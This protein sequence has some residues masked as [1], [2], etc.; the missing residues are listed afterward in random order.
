MSWVKTGVAAIALAA[1]GLAVAPHAALAGVVVSSSGPSAGDY[2]AGTKIGDDERITL[3]A[4]DTLTVLD[5]NGTRI[6]RGAGTYML[7]QRSAA[8]RS[9]A[10]AALTT[11]RSARRART[12][13]VR[14]TIEEVRNPNLWYVDVRKSGNVCLFDNGELN[15]WRPNTSEEAAYTVTQGGGSTTVVFPEGE[16]LGS[17]DAAMPIAEGAPYSIAGPDGQTSTVTFKAIDV[18]VEDPEALAAELIAQGCT[19]QL[20]QLTSASLIPAG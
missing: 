8:N 19:T 1:G 3:Q 17:L 13:A 4:G 18:D 20:E 5:E 9:R 15:L 14:G 16:M 11:N 10:I 6:L 7:S 2:P 12:G